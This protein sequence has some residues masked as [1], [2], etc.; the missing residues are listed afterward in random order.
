MSKVFLQHL[1]SKSDAASPGSMEQ[2]FYERALNEAEK[3][4]GYTLSN[5]KPFEYA[6]NLD[7]LPDIQGF[8]A[9]ILQCRNGN[10]YK[11]FTG[12][13]RKYML[14]AFN[15]FSDGVLKRHPPI[16]ILH[17]EVFDNRAEAMRRK[18][19][20]KSADGYNWLKTA[21]HTDLNTIKP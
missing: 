15:G 2:A 1:K 19:F 9:F 11:G 6:N 12:N 21:K 20:F 7:W 10:K 16:F 18:D 8:V 17:Y 13:L 5:E 3:F 4:F 14:A